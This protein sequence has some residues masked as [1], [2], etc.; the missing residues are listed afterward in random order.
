MAQSNNP[1]LTR[2][3]YVI[4]RVAWIKIFTLKARIQLTKSGE[5][6]LILKFLGCKVQ[7][8]V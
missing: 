4:W 2:G 8:Y 5:I 1:I 3:F 6:T 7:K